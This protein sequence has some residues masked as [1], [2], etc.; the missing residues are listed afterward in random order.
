[1][2][3]ELFQGMVG[4]LVIRVDARGL[5]YQFNDGDT[6]FSDLTFTLDDGVTGLIGRN[7]SGKSVL[8]SILAGE[9]APSSG[10]VT[11]SCRIGWMKQFGAEGN[12]FQYETIS[13]FLE[14]RGKLEALARVAAGGCD[15]HDFDLIGDQWLLREDQLRSLSLPADPFLPCRVLSGGQLTRLALHRF[16]HSRCDY[17]ILDEPGNHLDEEGKIWL[18][19]QLQKF[20]GGVLMISHDRDIL[21][22]VDGILE[23]NGLGLHRY[24]GNYDVFVE[25][26][27]NELAGQERRIKDAVKNMKQVRQTIQKNREKAR[28]RAVQGKQVARSGSQSKMIL[29]NKK[30]DAER[31]GG[32]RENRQNQHLETMK[33]EFDQLRQQHEMLKPQTLSLGKPEKRATRILDVTDVSLPYNDSHSS[34]TFSLD[35][36]EKIR[37]SGANGSGKSTLLKIISGHAAAAGGS[38]QVRARLCYLDQH[39]RLLDNAGSA[40][41]NLSVFCPHLMETDRRTLLA[42]IGLKRERADQAVSTLSGGEKMKVAMLAISHQSGDTLLLLDEPDNHLDMDSRLMLAKS[43]RDYAG[44]LLIVS[45]DN[46]FIADIGVTGEI[47]LTA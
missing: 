5:T 29:N 21:R 27:A 44:S 26:R 23:L 13:D 11:S 33:V 20:C 22:C 35:F 45:H 41:Q 17:L 9:V 40:L 7:G 16:L 14:V 34:I 24:G 43:L 30:Q 25:E 31:A 39:F 12:L 19:E 32:S 18:V 47:R 36:G 1:M 37:L 3:P 42:G 28:Q 46:D 15:P 6:L 10:S 38:I 4:G 8:A 2:V